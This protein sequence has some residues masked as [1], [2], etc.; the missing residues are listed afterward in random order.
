MPLQSIHAYPNDPLMSVQILPTSG[1]DTEVHFRSW[2]GFSF[3]GFGDTNVGFWLPV[4]LFGVG[5]Q[6]RDN[7]EVNSTEFAAFPLGIAWGLKV[8]LP[9]SSFYIGISAVANWSIVTST[10][11]DPMNPA[12]SV[13][14]VTHGNVALGLLLDIGNYVYIGVAATVDARTDMDRPDDQS[15]VTPSIVV[16]FAPGLLQV[17]Q[18]PF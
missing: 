10:T 11:E 13:E 9:R 18:S 16:G 15:R 8:Y 7:G 17:L 3:Y 12:E 2:N 4:G 6:L 5:F 1:G 14:S